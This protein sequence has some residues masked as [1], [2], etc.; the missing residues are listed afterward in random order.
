M[1]VRNLDYLL[2][3]RSV[4][5][6]GASDREGSVG[7]IVA[8][9]MLE[10]GFG[11][12]I[13]LVNPK[14]KMICGRQS[15]RSIDALPEPV[16]LGIVVTPAEVVPGVIGD[17]AKAG[18]RAAVVITAGIRG[19]LRDQ[20]LR[21]GQG[22]CLRI[23]GPN[24]LGLMLPCI[25][26]NASF[27]HVAP[28]AG[29]VAFLSQS[30]ALITGIVDWA[31]SRGVGFS[32]VVS[33]G[34]AADVDFGDLLDYLAGD[35]TSH[36]ILLYV[37]SISNAPKF[38][39]AA[40][41]AAR[42]KPVIVV[43]A[44]RHAT[45]AKAALSH[46]GALAGSDSAY[47][48]A[49]R[50]VGLVR[51]KELGELFDAAE[52]L[53]RMPK[54]AVETL[55]VL[56]NGGGAGVLA[57][58]RL[59]DIDGRLTTLSPDTIAALDAIL[60]PTWSK[61]NPIDIIGDAG[62]DR[63]EAAME[64]ILAA[65][66]V[67][68]VLAINCPTALVPSIETAEAILKPIEERRAASKPVKPVLTTWLGDTAAREARKL[69]VQHHLPTFE[70]PADAIKGFGTLTAYFRGQQA[71]MRTPH[72][73]PGEY[74]FNRDR[75]KAIL[76][77][78]A[79]HGRTMLTE[80]ES[81]ALLTTYGIPVATTMVAKDARE[82]RAA[83]VEV[84]QISD[85]CVLKI[86]SQ[87]ISHKSDVGGVRL[88][89]TTP[90]EVERAANDML[91]RTG[92]LRPDAR[93]DGLTVQ[94]MIRRPDAVE[95]I[96]GMSVDQ[97]FGP[98]VMFGAGGTS[99][100][101]VKDIAHALPPLDLLLADD[102]IGRTRVSRLLEAH[103]GKPAANRAALTEAL[104]R[105][106]YL[107]ADHPEILEL[108]IN[109]LLVD[110]DGVIALD[111][112]VH[113]AEEGVQPRTPMAIR[114]YPSGW[115]ADIEIGRAGDVHIRPIRPEDEV[116]YGD[117]FKLVEADDMRLRFF[118][119][120][121]HLSHAFL[122]RLTQID[123]AREMAFVALSKSEGEEKLLGVVRLIADADYESAEYAVL[124]RS[125]LKGEGL[126]WEL[127][128]HVIGYAASEG[129]QEVF[130]TVLAENTTMLK[131]CRQLGFEVMV[132]PEDQ[133]LRRVR[134]RGEAL[135]SYLAGN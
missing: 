123:Y 92:R 82:A 31:A 135:K 65:P 109:P 18:A 66:E 38:L 114:P 55:T 130:G 71:L 72:Q 67:D 115:E 120:R 75:A 51:V 27:A 132:D 39:S 12:A 49:F 70:T 4:A 23:Q 116:L 121:P 90:E 35:R 6:I 52:I 42:S 2:A 58:D 28:V 50:R 1:T 122:A 64:T 99:V 94:A 19:E 113:V 73:A 95:L 48:A 129:L 105:L 117:F 54:L 80:P 108:D 86:L 8:R 93:I 11:G 44:G 119:A 77:A 34:N 47:D 15:V 131:M 63:Y 41:R 100:E 26:L 124:V 32:H 5:L 33:L 112:R 10:G 102:L 104:V 87:D 88:S 103:R 22:V 85:A 21:A 127:M 62:A 125:D 16:D 83:A 126:G 61:N 110:A 37:E 24:C 111:A 3:P 84:L 98:I 106:S 9:N 101:V 29:D 133:M 17:L 57:A 53:A 128:Q 91:E 25:G 81:K 30:G 118:M 20:M 14:G 59:A 107:V 46:T 43:K 89:L 45:G 97:S 69:F 74:E 40:R 78:A 96:A 134:L 56:T 68:T 7:Q 76:D 79:Q 36:A 13:H 60:P